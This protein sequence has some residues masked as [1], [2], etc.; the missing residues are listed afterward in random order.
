MMHG[1]V[2]A[3]FLPCPLL[4][5]LPACAEQKV[6]RVERSETRGRRCRIDR[7]V[8]DFAALNP[9]YGSSALSDFGKGRCIVSTVHSDRRKSRTACWSVFERPRNFDTTAFASDAGY[10]AVSAVEN[11]K[12]WLIACKRS[13]VRPSWWRNN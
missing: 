2:T 7:A 4:L 12:C 10:A 9:G 1:G 5:P 13:L 3:Q 6:A 8:P 11:E